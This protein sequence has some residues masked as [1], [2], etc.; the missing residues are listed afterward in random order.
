MGEKSRIIHGMDGIVGNAT[1]GAKA[2][3]TQLD[4]PWLAIVLLQQN[5]DIGVGRHIGKRGKQ[6]DAVAGIRQC[7]QHSDRTH[8]TA[9]QRYRRIRYEQNIHGSRKNTLLPRL[10]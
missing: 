4:P 5:P 9:T 3:P 6:V 10:E 1:G 2:R 8:L 7:P